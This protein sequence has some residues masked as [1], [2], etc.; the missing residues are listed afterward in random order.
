VPAPRLATADDVTAIEALVHACYEPY[1]ARIGTRPL[2]MVDD[3]TARVGRAQAWVLD[4]DTAA[5]SMDPELAP[6]QVRLAGLIVLEESVD[7]LYVDNVAV[8]PG[9][10]GRGWGRVLLDFADE[11]A[12]RAGLP[13]L[14]LVTNELMTENRALYAHLGWVETGRVTIRGRHAVTFTKTLGNH[15]P[16]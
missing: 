1:V 15:R 3:Y 5:P 7:H 16:D 11:R 8:A 10:R 14:R 2:P 12:R 4:D 9:H 6:V 13:A